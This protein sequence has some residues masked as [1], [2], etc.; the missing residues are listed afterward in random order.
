M[1]PQNAKFLNDYMILKYQ[2]TNKENQTNSPVKNTVSQIKNPITETINILT[3]SKLTKLIYP[4]EVYVNDSTF[5][6]KKGNDIYHLRFIDKKTFYN[7]NNEEIVLI[8]ASY[9]IINGLESNQPILNL[10]VTDILD[11]EERNYILRGIV[12]VKCS[13]N[14]LIYNVRY[15]FNDVY[16]AIGN[17]NDLDENGNIKQYCYSLTKKFYSSAYTITLDKE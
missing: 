8:L 14:D 13:T 1:K 9:K 2:N 11:E 12:N 16:L 5:I 15:I 17:V 10:I 7:N 3:N 6:K 4:D